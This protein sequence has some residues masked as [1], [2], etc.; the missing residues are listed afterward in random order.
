[1]KTKHPSEDTPVPQ[2]VESVVEDL[3]QQ[4]VLPSGDASDVIPE[5]ETIVDLESQSG[6]WNE[7][8]G[9]PGHRASKV[10]LEDETSAAELLVGKGVNEADEELRDLDE[11][12]E[13]E[14]EQEEL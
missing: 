5:M 6:P 3:S 4:D 8:M 9:E 1:M 10:P 12:E 7:P 13:M 2:L 14:E 11:E